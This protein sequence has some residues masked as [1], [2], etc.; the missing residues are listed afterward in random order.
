ML[1]Q[2]FVEETAGYLGEYERKIAFCL[3]AVTD[4][5]LWWRPNP[6]SNSIGNLVLHLCG[7]L[8][9]WLLA[10]VGGRPY[11]R[12]R[13]AEF[14]ALGGA[15]AAELKARLAAVVAGCREV[16]SGLSDE[17]LARPHTIQGQDTDGFG[18]VLHVVE[19]MS[20]HTGQIL[21]LTKQLATDGRSIEF[22]PHLKQ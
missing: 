20:Y 8:S 14:A 2:R 10:G 15:G 6:W 13:P 21:T 3:D 18:A 22:Y 4:E 9:Q 12:D 5:Q 7:N 19:H 16:V 17:A 1:R 11:E